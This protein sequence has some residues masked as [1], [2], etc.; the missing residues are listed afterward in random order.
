L[1]S[2]STSVKAILRQPFGDQDEVQ[3]RRP[4]GQSFK[5]K[6]MIDGKAILCLDNEGSDHTGEIGHGWY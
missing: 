1:P 5:T 4:R 2:E 3:K 6:S